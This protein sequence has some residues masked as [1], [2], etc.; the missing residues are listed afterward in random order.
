MCYNG[1]IYFTNRNFW[2]VWWE[3]VFWVPLCFNRLFLTLRENNIGGKNYR[4]AEFALFSWLAE[5]QTVGWNQKHFS[6]CQWINGYQ[7]MLMFCKNFNFAPYKDF[8]E[9]CVW[10]DEKPVKFLFSIFLWQKSIQPMETIDAA[11]N[12]AW[13]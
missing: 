12:V 2:K 8:I 1:D 11:V 9:S 13:H 4:V 7:E 5:Y 3:G 6:L 10:Y